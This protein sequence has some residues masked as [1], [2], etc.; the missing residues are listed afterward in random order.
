MLLVMVWFL[1]RTSATF[2]VVVVLVEGCDSCV[3]AVRFKVVQTKQVLLFFVKVD[4]YVSV[5]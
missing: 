5:F 3:V 1:E 2:I 4:F